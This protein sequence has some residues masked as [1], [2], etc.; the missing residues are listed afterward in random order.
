MYHAY[1]QIIN[2][3]QTKKH[4]FSDEKYKEKVKQP[5]KNG[6]RPHFKKLMLHLLSA[7]IWQA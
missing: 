3:K 4:H 1:I 6:L 5:I 2:K 7:E